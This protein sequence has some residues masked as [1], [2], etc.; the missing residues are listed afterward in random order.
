MIARIWHGYTSTEN[1]KAYEQLLKNEVF[2]EIQGKEIP[3]F[4]HIKLLRRNMDTE[5]EFIT[6]MTFD[7]LA[8][9]REFAGEDYTRAYVPPAARD[10]LKRF[11]SHSQHYE[12]LHELDA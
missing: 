11:D 5:V 4:Q 7:D 8:S 9:V 1:A 10:I 3:G 2:L 12:V 6:I